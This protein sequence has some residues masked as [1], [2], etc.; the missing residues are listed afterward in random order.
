LKYDLAF[1]RLPHRTREKV[2]NWCNADRPISTVK[3][4][5]KGVLKRAG[6]PH[7]PIYTLRHVF[8]TRLSQVAPDAVVQRA[9]RHTRP[10]SKRR[11]QLG[12]ADQ[13][14]QAV[15]RAN[16]RAYGRNRVLR[17]YDVLPAAKK[18]E[19]IAVAK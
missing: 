10:E 19:K 3:T 12:M 17:F 8:C 16:K 9:M 11:Y 15:E 5:W 1:Q 6:V 13:V 2:R 7:F 4:A 14:R 18:E